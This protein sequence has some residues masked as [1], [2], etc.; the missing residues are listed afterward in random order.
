[1]PRQNRPIR[2]VNN[3]QR[4]VLNE[5]DARESWRMFRILAEFVDGIEALT[6][7]YP[8]VAVFGSARTRPESTNYQV[9]ETIAKGLAESGY[10]IVTGGG[11][12]VM[13]AANKG[14]MEAGGISAGLN[15]KLPHEQRPNPYASISLD[16][17]Y[18]FIRKVMLVKYAVAFVCLPGGYGTLDEFFEAITLIQTRKIKPFPVI[19]VGSDFWKGL[20]GWLEKTVYEQGM[21]SPEDL[22][23]FH[24]LDDPYQV[25]ETIKREAPLE[26]M[27]GASCPVK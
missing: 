19:L 3:E 8:A 23:L 10:S 13:E 25:V 12:G 20:L 5:L 24:I 11:P 6:K 4:Y 22:T 7:I 26:S 2:T 27:L 18:F 1:M 21:I 15:I 14:A 9:A 17:R 16:F